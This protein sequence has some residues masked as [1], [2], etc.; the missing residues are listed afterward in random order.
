MHAIVGGFQTGRIAL[1][2]KVVL[3]GERKG[4]PTPKH[5]LLAREFK[6]VC[7]S[8]T[9]APN[10]VFANS[11]NPYL[12]MSAMVLEDHGRTGQPPCARVAFPLLSR[13]TLSRPVTTARH[14]DSEICA[15][16]WWWKN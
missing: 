3:L 2:C 11:A 13:D 8:P 6:S 12:G 10:G 9:L 15:S 16:G 14:T 4:N 7:V 1:A 5:F